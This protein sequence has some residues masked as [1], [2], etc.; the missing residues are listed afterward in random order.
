MSRKSVL[1]G[2]GAVSKGESLF[3]HF[4]K[5]EIKWLI[6]VFACFFFFFEKCPFN[7]WW[8]PCQNIHLLLSENLTDIWQ[9]KCFLGP[10]LSLQTHS[11]A[12]FNPWRVSGKRWLLQTS[13]PEE[14][15]STAHWTVLRNERYI[16]SSAP[17]AG[18]KSTQ[19]V[20]K[21]TAFSHMRESPETCA[22]ATRNNVCK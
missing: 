1:K 5:T 2:G 9:S 21:N 4:E 19:R 17:S 11:S 8:S 15:L 20:Q 22:G 12:V 16:T 7:C 14:V 13:R 10:S 18:A 3:L 6:S